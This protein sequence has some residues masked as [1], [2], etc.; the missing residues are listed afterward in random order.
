[1]PKLSMPNL[2]PVTGKDI[3]RFGHSEFDD[4]SVGNMEQED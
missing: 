4:S 3:D 1:M 2:K